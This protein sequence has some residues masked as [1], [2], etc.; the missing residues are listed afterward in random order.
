M[1]RAPALAAFAALALAACVGPGAIPGGTPVP[2]ADLLI[3]GGTVYDGVSEAGR[4]VDVAV[5]G[6]TVLLIGDAGRMSAAR[7]IDATG[8]IV[9]PGF[10]DPHTHSDDDLASPDRERRFMANHLMQGVTTIV[11]G[12]DGGGPPE[13]GQRFEAIRAGGAGANVAAFVGFGA[14]RR[15]ILGEV[16]RAPNAAELAAMR[17]LVAT[18]M[19]EGAL[20]LS[21]GL[22]YA[23]QS[24]ART[25]EVI[26]LARE[27]AA[28]DGIY[29]THLRD[30]GSGALGLMA[31]LEEALEI[32]RTA[33]LPVHIA[34]IKALGVAAHG[35]APAAIARIDDARRSGLRVSAD[36][37][38]WTASGTRLTALVPGWALDGGRDALRARIADAAIFPRLEVEVAAQIVR[39][40]GPDAILL[41]GGDHRGQRL[42]ALARSWS[43]TPAA[44]ALRV[45]AA[46]DAPIASFNMRDSDLL[47]FRAQ[48]WV[49]TG[50]DASAGHPRR[51][52][53][54]AR[55]WRLYVRERSLLSPGRFIR[56]SS[57][58]T[59]E[60]FG[61]GPRGT[62]RSR[63]PA[64]LVVFAPAA[65]AEGA[66]YGDPT[67]LA[68]GVRLVL[69]NGAVA[70]DQGRPTGALA[71]RPLPHTA[72]QRSCPN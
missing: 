15:R 56:R 50:S 18:A 4:R 28:R 10:V 19:C 39:R 68:T 51:F 35:Q 23:P 46:G 45:I 40:G 33:G 32:G 27:A 1:L 8:M 11:V 53:S 67:A 47:A 60:L 26:A 70:V 14:V 62:L 17:A 16:D 22:Y 71:G 5:R 3:R 42:D 72:A 29:E 69:V 2:R 61:L 7:T 6:D 52:G 12:N 66:D 13:L 37:Y 30:E 38:P 43:V 21:A 9:A 49:V 41:T 65:F 58:L 57:G 36:H 64:D 20:G 24:F 25:A 59:A 48:P 34:H 31:A 44:A 55:A 63:G 54:F